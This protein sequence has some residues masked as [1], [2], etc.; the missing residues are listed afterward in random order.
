[1]PR[2]RRTIVSVT[3]ALALGWVASSETS[4]TDQV[5][6]QYRRVWKPQVDAALAA[7]ETVRVSGEPYFAA[8]VRDGVF[9]YLA[10][11]LEQNTVGITTG[12]QLR[13]ILAAG[14]RKSRIP[15][16]CIASLQRVPGQVPAEAWVRAIF[17]APL[18][19][20]V[21]YSILGYHPGSV[22][23]SREVTVHEWHLPRAELTD[24]GTGRSGTFMVED[25]TVWGV[26]DGEVLVDID[27]WLDALM[28]GSLDD[29]Y[30]VALALFRFRGQPY[31][32][33]LG[34]NRQGEPRSGSLQLT[35]DEI[36]FPSPPELKAIARALRARAVRRLA[37]MGLPVWL[38]R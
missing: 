37:Q 21:P 23:S 3:L 28:A 19:V 25:L 34:Y 10:G 15:C 8:D 9:A 20:P 12:A 11:L 18:D 35:E 26:I 24:P 7:A 16:A 27:G 14:G 22:R 6:E 29:T 38:P 17:T 33:A 13:R 32:M 30:V 1:M 4:S 2:I 31:A 36:C 5:A